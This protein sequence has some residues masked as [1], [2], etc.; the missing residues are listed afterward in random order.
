MEQPCPSKDFTSSQKQYFAHLTEALFN[1]MNESLNLPYEQN[2]ETKEW[3][4]IIPG[5]T[6]KITSTSHGSRN[7]L[8]HSI[9]SALYVHKYFSEKLE[10]VTGL[11]HDTSVL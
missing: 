2:Q 11:D 8:G 7:V 1:K 9:W 5:S 10:W 3:V 4:P 6:K